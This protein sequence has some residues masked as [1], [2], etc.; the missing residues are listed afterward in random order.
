MPGFALN[1]KATGAEVAENA[2]LGYTIGTY[3]LKMD[4][5]DGNPTTT[6]GKYVTVW[7]KQADGGWKVPS[8]VSTPTAH[9]QAPSRTAV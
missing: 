8:T 7:E 1:W 9:R 6:V 4:D 3:E 2:D 5:A